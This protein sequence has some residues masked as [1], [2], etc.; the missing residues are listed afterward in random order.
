MASNA[1][2]GAHRRYAFAALF[3]RV[4]LSAGFL[5]AVADRFGLWG[6]VGT[7][8][9]AWGDLDA[10]QQYVHELAPYLPVMLVG[11]VGWIATVAEIVVGLALL[12][13]VATRW[14]AAASAATL[15]VFGLSMFFFSDYEAPL[16]MSVFSAAAAAALLALSPAHSSWRI[17]WH[18]RNDGRTP[19]WESA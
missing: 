13:G 4:A 12:L 18:L 15:L 14:A 6:P 16:G 17:L 7:G 2:D 11:V 3:A 19:S 9:V 8:A 5:A 10:Y 1:Q